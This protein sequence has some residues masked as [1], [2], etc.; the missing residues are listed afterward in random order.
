MAFTGK[1]VYLYV[2][3]C[4]YLNRIKMHKTM[5]TEFLETLVLAI[6]ID[7]FGFHYKQ[8]A[9]DQK[10]FTFVKFASEFFSSAEEC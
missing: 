5:E 8:Y 3:K 1:L 4:I 2:Y 6:K 7:I 10:D 9:S